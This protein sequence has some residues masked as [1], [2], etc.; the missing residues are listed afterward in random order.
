MKPAYFLIIV[1]L[2]VLALLIFYFFFPNMDATYPPS[3]NPH[4]PARPTGVPPKPR[5]VK[6]IE[7]DSVLRINESKVI[8][9]LK[10]IAS[11]QTDYNNNFAPHSYAESLSCLASGNG[12]GGISFLDD[13][14][15]CGR[16]AGYN[17]QMKAGRLD[18]SGCSWSWS[19][20]AWPVVYS[21][22]G[23]N[24][25]YI[26]EMGDIR[27]EGIQGKIADEKSENWTGFKQYESDGN[28]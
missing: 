26:D 11:A 14:A 2:A 15:S 27:Y 20:V 7:A 23:K 18:E 4:Y 25:Y 6:P 24:S 19:C 8:A 3:S 12:A 5:T 28:P 17:F 21:E 22:T 13:P 10:R 1:G 16:S 9:S